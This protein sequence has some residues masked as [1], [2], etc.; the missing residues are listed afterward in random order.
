[1]KNYI[2]P[3]FSEV[4]IDIADVILVSLLDEGHDIYDYS[5]ELQEKKTYEE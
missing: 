1:M 5:D 2:K 4:K 3:D